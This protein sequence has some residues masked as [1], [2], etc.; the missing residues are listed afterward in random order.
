MATQVDEHRNEVVPLDRRSKDIRIIHAQSFYIVSG[1]HPVRSSGLLRPAF[2]ELMLVLVQVAVASNDFGKLAWDE[3]KS[4][5]K[6]EVRQRL[7]VLENI[8]IPRITP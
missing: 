8:S 2:T 4:V 7:K 5:H 1:H 3:S 6:F